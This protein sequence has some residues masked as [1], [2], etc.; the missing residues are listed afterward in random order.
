M[1]VPRGQ[2][3]RQTGHLSCLSHVKLLLS[4]HG[5]KLNEFPSD[6]LFLFAIVLLLSCGAGFYAEVA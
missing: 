2:C 3:A 4:F 5:G 1:E 6:D